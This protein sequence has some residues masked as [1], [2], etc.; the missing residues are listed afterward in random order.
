MTKSV[1]YVFVVFQ[2]N[3]NDNF[4]TNN[5]VRGNQFTWYILYKPD[6]ETKIGTYLTMLF[7]KQKK[8]AYILHLVFHSVWPI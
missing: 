4:S 6:G 8:I 7:L 2:W 3:I 5:L 1:E